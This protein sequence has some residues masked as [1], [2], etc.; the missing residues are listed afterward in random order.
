MQPSGNTEALYADIRETYD[1]ELPEILEAAQ[2][3]SLH[4]KGLSDVGQKHALCILMN[5]WIRAIYPDDTEMALKLSDKMRE[6]VDMYIDGIRRGDM[7][8]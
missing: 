3:M 6:Q 1:R 8:N 4:L 2:A 5:A 7:V